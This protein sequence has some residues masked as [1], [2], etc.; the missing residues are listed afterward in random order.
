MTKQ[1]PLAHGAIPPSKPVTD[2]ALE[3]FRLGELPPKEIEA[4]Q[5][6]LSHDAA[7]RERLRVLETQEVEFLKSHPAENWVSRIENASNPKPVLPSQSSATRPAKSAGGFSRLTNGFLDHLRFFDQRRTQFAF[8]FAALVLATIPVWLQQPSK[9]E[10]GIRLKGQSAELKLYCKTDT[11]ASPL[12]PGAQVKAG[13]A[14]QIEFHPGLYGFGAIVSVDGKGSVTWHWP[15]SPEGNSRIVTLADFRLPNAFQLDSAPRFE[16][17]YLVLSKD[18][19]DL[20]SLGANLAESSR[21]DVEWISKR[22][23]QGEQDGQRDPNVKVIAFPLLK[24]P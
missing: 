9:M 13:D 20:N 12:K 6:R 23:S 2:F 22:I 3:R 14:I 18:S 11:G 10:A 19:L 17:F 4:M 21:Q 1:N 5:L 24:A 7:L 16:R 15:A 8:G